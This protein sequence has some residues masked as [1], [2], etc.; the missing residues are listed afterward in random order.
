M[1]SR[2]WNNVKF[3]LLALFSQQEAE[4]KSWED[5]E[6]RKQQD[7]RSPALVTKTSIPK[8]SCSEINRTKLE[9]LLKIEQPIDFSSEK[10]ILFLPPFPKDAGEFVPVLSLKYRPG[11]KPEKECINFRLVMYHLDE[12]GTSCGFGFRLESPTS[13]CKENQTESVH[14]FYHI[15]LI[16][17]MGIGGN[18]GPPLGLPDWL[19]STQPAICIRANNPVDAILNLVLSLYGMDYYKG[20]LK[21]VKSRIQTNTDL[22]RSFL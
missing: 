6:L 15:Q 7:K 17:E 8:W 12:K 14:D 11:N 4:W 21:H 16:T 3:V 22:M 20:F 2:Y 1:P 9:N 18:Y 10:L 19:P 5:K 13:N